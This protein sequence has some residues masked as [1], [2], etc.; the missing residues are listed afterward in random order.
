MIQKVGLYNDPR[1]QLPWVVRWFGEYDPI[2]GKQSRYS[3]S[4]KLKRDAEAFQAEKANEF[5]KGEQRDKPEEISLKRFCDDYVKTRKADV[6]PHTITLYELSTRQLIGY[7]GGAMTLRLIQP[8][9]AAKFIADLKPIS[10]TREQL[11]S[12]SRHRILR[13]CKTMFEAAVTWGL[14]PVNPF[15]KIQRPKLVQQKWYY[16]KP[17]EY[18]RLLNVVPLR[19]KVFYSLAY[20]CGLRFGELVSLT[21]GDIDFE[22]GEICLENRPATAETPAFFVKDSE[23][24][25]IP[26]PKHT[27]DLLTQLQAQ[28]TEGIPYVV[29]SESQYQTLISK[30]HRF[31]KQNKPLRNQDM[32]N[33]Y[34]TNFKRHLKWAKIKPNG[35][36]SL[37]TLRK[38]CITNWANNINN[39]EVVRVLAGHSD[40]KTTMQFYSKID[41]DQR[42]KAAKVA[43]DLLEKTDAR[44]TPEVKKG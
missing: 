24:R 19:M 25:R 26:L 20:C 21:W 23:S 16:L 30:W 28:A 2:T 9:M 6:R 13:N 31:K 3:K 5:R 37:H 4:F 41:K 42:A 18:T 10:T 17:E 44:L 11:S 34:L 38:C 22:T 33:N 36:L 29:L 39:P 1:K 43:D 12:W 32:M 8:R 15:S 40:L 7:F 27:L 35:S 14:I